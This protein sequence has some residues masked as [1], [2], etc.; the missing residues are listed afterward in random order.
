MP[1]RKPKNRG[2]SRSREGKSRKLKSLRGLYR[3]AKTC[4]GAGLSVIPVRADGSK[5]PAGDRLP[6]G[7]W[8]QFQDRRPTLAELREW[9][10]SEDAVDPSVGIAVIAG[11]ISG[12]LEVLDIDSG[13]Y[14]GPWKSFVEKAAPGLLD[15]LVLVRTPRPGLHVYFRSAECAGN[16]KLARVPVKDKSTGKRT[17]KV[18]A[19][20]RGEGGYV[21]APPSPASCHPTG[22]IYR[23]ADDKDLAQ[24]P[25]I[26]ADERAVLLDAARA[27][28]RWQDPRE[29]REF[30]Q[31]VQR[32]GS[33]A[34]G[35]RP[36]DVFNARGDWCE[37][38]E[39]HGWKRLFVGRD[40]TEYW[41]RPGKP[42][43]GSSATVNHGGFDLLYVFSANADPFEA[44]RA[45]TKFHALALLEFDGE[46][47]SAATALAARG[48][49]QR[50]SRFRNR[51]KKTRR[52][53]FDR[54][55]E[56]STPANWRY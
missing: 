36:G 49:G 22:R 9:F 21:L 48:F 44:N 14:V 51:R 32:S 55:S 40:G 12:G 29:R 47:K 17:S 18:I 7:S 13:K 2:L 8:K 1:D 54:Y 56:Y 24:I 46:F 6:H 4:I 37:I 11:K 27:L 23:L 38:L 10:R 3:A 39:P 15:R 16:Q 26:T 25:T 43:G 28:N 31:R 20:T 50:R 52:T 41:R 34:T 19:E 30:E 53:A 35:S 5:S 33:A 45:Y 42:V